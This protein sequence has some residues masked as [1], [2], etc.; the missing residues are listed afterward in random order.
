M[1]RNRFIIINLALHNLKSKK[2][3]SLVIAFSISL[4]FLGI[5]ASDSLGNGVQKGINEL[6]VSG[7]VPINSIVQVKSDSGN[8]VPFLE[9]DKQEI[10]KN[11]G[12]D[13]IVSFE[14]PYSIS[15]ESVV[16]K[17]KEYLDDSNPSFD[18][19]IESENQNQKSS[20][21]DK[22]KLYDSLSTIPEGITISERI[23][24][25][26]FPN[27]DVKS[28]LGQDI[29]LKIVQ[30]NFDSKSEVRKTFK[31][32]NIMKEEIVGEDLDCYLSRSEFDKMVKDG[33]IIKQSFSGTIQAAN[34][35]NLKE[36]N[37]TI[38]EKMGKK[39][40]V[41]S[42]YGIIDFFQKGVLAIQSVIIFFSSLLLM[43][44]GI[45]LSVVL[46][47]S[48]IQRTKEFATML[49]IGYKRS[50]I[51]KIIFYESFLIIL[52]AFIIG[53][54]LY[55]L[56]TYIVMYNLPADFRSVELFILTSE[57]IF[58][59]ILVIIILSLISSIFPAIKT[60][61]NDPV[62]SLRYE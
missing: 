18:I 11:V 23:I 1:K 36:I 44:S 43:I 20:Y 3:R 41:T 58:K 50:S 19:K 55:K 8:P 33:Y 6:I 27:E 57:I 35:E 42:F 37:K 46:Y 28:F 7:Q 38:D 26:M 22:S 60:L 17:G 31:I 45:L 14:I 52:T 39:Y 29:E 48:V 21:N 5:L 54:L 30:R 24:E 61:S 32:K 34:V 2:I 9:E 47:I 51:I 12:S 49:A 13:K 56:L 25:T 16:I 15:S 40:T 59:N 53:A 4:G 62:D 10:I